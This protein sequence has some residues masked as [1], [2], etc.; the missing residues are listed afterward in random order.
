MPL[1]IHG[2]VPPLPAWRCLAAPYPGCSTGQ[3]VARGAA[4]F[5]RPR[6][7]AMNRETDLELGAFDASP[8]TLRY[9]SPALADPATR[10][11]GGRLRWGLRLCTGL[12]RTAD[13]DFARLH[14][15]KC[16]RITPW[17]RSIARDDA[18]YAHGRRGGLERALAQL[19]SRAVPA[20]F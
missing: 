10:R 2:A 5:D 7:A 1:R 17:L 11:I 14:C 4:P 18:G 19:D 20:L 12:C 8:P 15:I 3:L 9:R 16:A 13:H 6:M